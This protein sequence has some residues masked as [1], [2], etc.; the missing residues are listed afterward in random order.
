MIE[1]PE[2]VQ[3]SWQVY[4]PSYQR[5][6]PQSSAFPAGKNG[7]FQTQHVGGQPGNLLFPILFLQCSLLLCIQN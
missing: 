4:T 2:T 1:E 5:P 3:G 6:R 7:T